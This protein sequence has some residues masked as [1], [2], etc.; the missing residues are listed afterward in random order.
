VRSAPSTC[1]AGDGREGQEDVEATGNA[2]GPL[3]LIDKYGAERAINHGALQANKRRQHCASHQLR[4]EG[5]RN[6]PT[7]LWMRRALP[8]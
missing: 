3:E 5:S 1:R 6:S 7:K 8:R 4:V 2:Y